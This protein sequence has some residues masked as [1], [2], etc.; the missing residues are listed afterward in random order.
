M[1]IE[2]NK[3]TAYICK[4][5]LAQIKILQLE[6]TGT[7]TNTDSEYI[8]QC[9]VASRRLRAALNIFSTWFLSED[10][11]KWNKITGKITKT[12][13]FARDID[14][15]I[16]YMEKW[17]TTH[18][19]PGAKRLLLRL[20]QKRDKL[21]NNVIKTAEDIESRNPFMLFANKISAMYTVASFSETT[22]EECFTNEIKTVLISLFH[23]LL[24]HEM[25]IND[26]P[27]ENN[28]YPRLH[29]MRI[30]AKKLRYALNLTNDAFGNCF[31]DDIKVIKKIQELLGDLH[32]CD[33]WISQLP[34]FIAEEKK[35]MAIY[36]GNTRG[37]SR[38]FTGL[39][40]IYDD[41]LLLRNEIIDTFKAYWKDL[42]KNNHW[43]NFLV[44]INSAQAILDS[45]ND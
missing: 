38:I 39:N 19:N 28:Q 3:A 16:I 25:Y 18:P 33:V 11:K 31:T 9:R 2:S 7:K 23:K 12:L 10:L 8:H 15:Q 43:K 35:I 21:Q 22:G 5:I 27:D 4:I 26:N 20:Q 14:V 32:D 41:R 42:K 34:L 29:E 40:E 37:F 36:T 17:I 30:S 44:N 45:K 1:P 24:S 6:A 13:G